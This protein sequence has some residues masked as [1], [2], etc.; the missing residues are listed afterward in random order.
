MSRPERG[1][2]D[3][4]NADRQPPPEQRRSG[5]AQPSGTKDVS[6]TN[7]NSSLRDTT[8]Q[9]RLTLWQ[10]LFGQGKQRASRR[11]ALQQARRKSIQTAGI[12]PPPNFLQ[13]LKYR[14]KPVSREQAASKLAETQVRQAVDGRSRQVS[15]WSPTSNPSAESPKG[16]QSVRQDSWRRGMAKPNSLQGSGSQAMT[17]LQPSSVDRRAQAKAL[18]LKREARERSRRGDSALRK[19]ISDLSARAQATERSKAHSEAQT[20]KRDRPSQPRSRSF[21]AGLYAARML[22]LSVGIGVLV[23]TMLSVLDPA[24]RSS[25]GASQQA[26]KK[27]DAAASA[28]STQP[29]TS[30]QNG[31]SPESASDVELPKMGQELTSLKAAL[32]ALALQNPR[33]TPGIFLYD[34]DTSSYLDL[35]GGASFAAASTIKVPIL[36]AFFQDVDAG[37]IRLDELLTMRKE[38]VGG[39]SGEMQGMPIGTQFTALETVTKMITISDNTA[40]NMVIARLGGMTALDQ[41]FQSWG[42]V[43]TAVNSLLPDLSGTNTTSP[44]DMALLMTRI[45]QGELVSMRSRDRLLDIM[46]R[47][48]NR[49]QLPQGLGKGATI[50]HKTG[51]I[52]GLIGDVGLI[53]MPNGKRYALTVLIKRSHNDDQAYDLVQKASRTVYQYLNRTPAASGTQ[54]VVPETSSQSIPAAGSDISSLDSSVPMETGATQ[55]P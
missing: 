33:L 38:L 44:K 25:A 18:T 12:V 3:Y 49:S 29:A 15:S 41:R 35:N 14:S 11:S 53:D 47:T 13:R 16:K 43:S 31:L 32:Q 6:P 21:S 19:S 22:I 39:G 40:T 10:V 50:A 7:G 1:S 42:L 5:K 24:A 37:K 20:R 9:Q 27:A 23:G 55:S 46:Q 51:D 8:R 17:V 30:A 28:Q 54:A 34:L 52:G 45:S 48:V 4:A 26:G 2:R 36:I